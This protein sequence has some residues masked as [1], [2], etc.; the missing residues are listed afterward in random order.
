MIFSQLGQLAFFTAAAMKWPLT[1]L[2]LRESPAQK[3]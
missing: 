2:S 1:S 3:G